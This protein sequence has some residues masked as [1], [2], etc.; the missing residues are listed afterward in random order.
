MK[1]IFMKTYADL[2]LNHHYL[3]IESEG[4]S[5]VL[6]EPILATENCFLNILHDD[7][8]T[9]FWRKKTDP[10]FEIVEELTEE[11]F[12]EYESLFEEEDEDVYDI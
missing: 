2:T 9:T 11:Q 6:V 10:I 1:I 7:E 3:L 8:E 12:D 4:E 5:I